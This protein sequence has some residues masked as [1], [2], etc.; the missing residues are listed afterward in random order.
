MSGW[1][2]AA[3]Y[4]V[5]ALA[6]AGL[7]LLGRT[8]A[9]RLSEDFEL[10]S[11]Q[12]ATWWGATVGLVVVIYRVPSGAVGLACSALL[13]ASV[14]VV[15]AIEARGDGM[16]QRFAFA[17]VFLGFCLASHAYLV[18][19][20][21]LDGVAAS[22]ALARSLHPLWQRVVLAPFER[23]G[24]AWALDGAGAGL[25]RIPEQTLS[26][27]LLFVAAA[28]ALMFAS[29][30]FSYLGGRAAVRPG[31]DRLP[32]ATLVSAAFGVAWLLAWF[33]PGN[34]AGSARVVAVFMSPVFALEGGL[35][36]WRAVA[37]LRLRAAL[38]AVALGGTLF[39]PGLAIGLVVLGWV[40]QVA[41]L[42]EFRPLI[43]ATEWTQQRPR[44]AV[45][46]LGLLLAGSGIAWKGADAMRELAVFPGPGSALV[47]AGQ[48]G[49]S[50]LD[51]LLGTRAVPT[52]KRTV[53]A[54]EPEPEGVAT[55]RAPSLSILVFGD[56]VL[57]GHAGQR[58]QSDPTFDPLDALAPLIR[59]ADVRIAHWVSPVP[60]GASRQNESDTRG[61]ALDPFKRAG[62]GWVAAA[63]SQMLSAGTPGLAR[64][65]VALG[66]SGIKVAGL[67]PAE[68]AEAWSRMATRGWNIALISAWD[69]SA[70]SID[71]QPTPAHPFVVVEPEALQASVRAARATADAVIVTLSG[72]RDSEGPATEERALARLLIGAGAD[73]VFSRAGSSV[74][75]VEWISGRPVFYG[76][77]ALVHDEV[78][79]SPWSA[80]GVV[81]RLTLQGSNHGP[82]EVALCPFLVAEGTPRL[83]A[84]SSRTLH[85]GV[86]RRAITR[87]STPL[88]GLHAGDPGLFSCLPISRSSH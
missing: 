59:S 65:L 28:A 88:G 69:E 15:G 55:P 77:G 58:M 11:P 46:P 1:V 7:V 5:L 14:L 6:G 85:E 41:F 25:V 71:E 16:R 35:V 72:T 48:G 52:P 39:L 68:G 4:A 78:A 9:D 81:A 57:S 66:E 36:L 62:L 29:G 44:L 21:M 45:L 2:L 74:S 20:E 84:G 49:L 43:G 37:R 33:A 24:A 38:A 50:D 17:H 27:H 40:Y 13:L 56:V 79:G 53:A 19:R 51:C 73:A 64:T 26:E 80:R 54:P 67:R 76:L 8:L 3:F 87:A 32:L 83:L 10:S 23:A 86:F 70:D 12:R 22:E 31:V 75:G 47:D 61:V 30:C 42:W 18:R 34:V 63:N 82:A 60:A